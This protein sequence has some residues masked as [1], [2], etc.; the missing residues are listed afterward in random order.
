MVVGLCQKLYFFRTIA[1]EHRIINDEYICAVFR[2]QG[3]DRVPDNPRSQQSCKTY[4]VNLEHLHEPIH[5][6][7]SKSGSISSSDQ[8]HIHT[9]VRKDQQKKILKNLN[10]GNAFFL[11]GIRCFQCRG[12]MESFKKFFDRF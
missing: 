4:P 9:P 6:I 10:N 1:F 3:D 5:R 2:V 12:D 11:I 8:A 7:L